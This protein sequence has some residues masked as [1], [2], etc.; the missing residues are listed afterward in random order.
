[1]LLAPTSSRPSSGPS[2]RPGRDLMPETLPLGHSG[3]RGLVDSASCLDSMGLGCLALIL[4]CHLRSTRRLRSRHPWRTPRGAAG[5]AASA[6]RRQVPNVLTAMRVLLVVPIVALFCWGDRRL[7]TVLFALSSLTDFLDGY[8]ARRWE[9]TSPFGKFL[10]PVADKLLACS[11]LVLLPTASGSAFAPGLLAVPAVLIILREIFVSALREWTAM[12]GHSTSTQVGFLGK[13]KTAVILVSLCG[14]LATCDQGLSSSIFRVAVLLLYLGTL[15]AYVSS[16]DYVRKSSVSSQRVQELAKSLDQ[17][18]GTAILLPKALNI[19]GRS[20]SSAK[21]LRE[22]KTKSR[23]RLVQL[24]PG[25]ALFV[26]KFENLSEEYAVMAALRQLNY[27]WQKSQLCVGQELVQAQTFGIFPLSPGLGLVEVVS[28][29]RTLRELSEG[30]PFNE[31]QWRVVRALN[32]DSQKLDRLA[33]SVCAYLTSSYVLGI[34]DGHDDNLMLRRDGRLFRVDFGFA[35][36][37]TPEID[38][39]GIFVPNAVYLALGEGRWRQVVLGCKAALRAVSGSRAD[40]PAWECLGK[41]PELKPLLP[42]VHEYVSSL[43]LSSFDHQVERAADWTLQRAAKNTLREA[44]RYVTAEQEVEENTWYGFLDPFGL[45]TTETTPPRTPAT[46][47]TPLTPTALPAPALSPPTARAERMERIP[48]SRCFAVRDLAD[49]MAVGDRGSTRRLCRALRKLRSREEGLQLVQ[50]QLNARPSGAETCGLIDAFAR[51][52]WFYRPLVDL[53]SQQLSTGT[54]TSPPHLA[55]TL[56][57]LATLHPPSL[58]RWRG[59]L[60]APPVGRRHGW[61]A[62]VVLLRSLLLAEVVMDGLLGKVFSWTSQQGSWTSQPAHLRSSGALW[63]ALCDVAWILERR[64]PASLK[65]LT[66]REKATLELVQSWPGVA[67]PVSGISEALELHVSAAFQRLGRTVDGLHRPSG[68]RSGHRRLPLSLPELKLVL[69]CLDQRSFIY[70]LQDGRSWLKPL[71]LL[72]QQQ[73]ET[74]GW[75]VEVILD[76]EWPEQHLEQELL[77]RKKLAHALQAHVPRRRR[78]RLP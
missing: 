8:L 50:Q 43:S 1:M 24:E 38:A 31:R 71:T 60:N 23:A 69:F 63:G 72:H 47:V 28:E 46:P 55:V 16:A 25:Q 42:E 67:Q 14:L 13:L 41:V 2:G 57:A 27:L 49:A 21:I 6:L 17:P 54:S 39:P 19:A 15:L 70:D 30:V 45:L 56:R 65:P 75:R 51:Q 29:S 77:L 20:F 53:A 58:A 3:A 35:W 74:A 64:P 61:F 7:C 66:D 11:V 32:Q 37:R 44:L 12:A 22:F 4:P 10:D 5:S 36:G 40:K 33:A 52:G 73:L 34:R 48:E 68:A 78:R 62:A 76:S 18:V 59:P 9:V 26:V